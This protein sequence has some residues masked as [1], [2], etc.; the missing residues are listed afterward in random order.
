MNL[1]EYKCNMGICYLAPSD[2]DEVIE[3][4][5]RLFEEEIQQKF[6]LMA[7]VVSVEPYDLEEA[8][9]LSMSVSCFIPDAIPE[10]EIESTLRKI[11]QSLNVEDYGIEKKN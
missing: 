11:L 9:K 8:S 6:G 2:K 3:T 10:Q 5:T 7:E 4:Q 1:R